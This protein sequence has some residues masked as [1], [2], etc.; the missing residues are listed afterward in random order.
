MGMLVCIAKKSLAEV[1]TLI[2]LL[3]TCIIIAFLGCIFSL[4]YGWHPVAG[5]CLLL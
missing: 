1:A 3:S 4:Y 5:L 2:E